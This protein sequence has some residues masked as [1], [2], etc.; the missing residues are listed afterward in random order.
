M[1]SDRKAGNGV[2]SEHSKLKEDTLLLASGLYA[3]VAGL[4]ITTAIEALLKI[5]SVTIVYPNGTTVTTP[6]VIVQ[7]FDLFNHL[8]SSM[9]FLTFFLFAIPF[10]HGAIIALSKTIRSTEPKFF[11]RTVIDFLALF[12]EAG[13]LYTLALSITSYRIFL[14][15]L[16][17]L[18]GLDVVWLL[19]ALRFGY[20]TDLMK[21]TFRNWLK[22]DL[23]IISYL[24][25]FRVILPSTLLRADDPLIV[26]VSLLA[27]SSV[28]TAIDYGKNLELYFP[29]YQRS[30]RHAGNL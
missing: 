17:I 16:L 8:K 14:S 4:A 27:V 26:Y 22:L 2:E 5:P 3:I 12:L 6:P 23:L 1:S 15:W 29:T 24:I 21:R 11:R 18:H 20:E 28:R 30:K 13:V 19:L 9:V 7:P 25:V 10:Y